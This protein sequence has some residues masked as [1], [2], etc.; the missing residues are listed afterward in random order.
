MIED[1]NTNK[2]QS[3]EKKLF[4]RPERI[5]FLLSSKNTIFIM[6]YLNSNSKHLP[7]TSLKLVK[8]LVCRPVMAVITTTI[9]WRGC[10]Q[11]LLSRIVQEGCWGRCKFLAIVN[12]AKRVW[13]TE[14]KRK[15]LDFSPQGFEPQSYSVIILPELSD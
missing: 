13:I 7:N 3:F 11:L 9:Y 6:A 14:T 15:G 1:C 2:S 5:F 10:G 12:Y 4:W 8:S